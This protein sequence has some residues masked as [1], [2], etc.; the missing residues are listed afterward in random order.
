MKKLVLVAVA[1]CLSVIWV[2]AISASTPGTDVRLTHDV[3]AG[4]SPEGIQRGFPVRCLAHNVCFCG[5]PDF[6]VAFS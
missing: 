1:A 3:S 5:V 2:S 6:G 4:I